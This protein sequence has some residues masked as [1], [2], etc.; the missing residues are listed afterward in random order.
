[1]FNQWVDGQPWWMTLLL[2]PAVVLGAI[3][4]KVVRYAVVVLAVVAILAAVA[5]WAVVRRRR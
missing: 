3:A 4:V 5:V 2:L 1:M